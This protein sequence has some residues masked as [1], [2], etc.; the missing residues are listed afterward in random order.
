MNSAIVNTMNGAT[1][2]ATNSAT[3]IPPTGSTAIRP[4]P[5]AHIIIRN[6]DINSDD[7]TTEEYYSDLEGDESGIDD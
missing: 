5:L 7:N 4:F 2:N 1:I 3:N 6:L